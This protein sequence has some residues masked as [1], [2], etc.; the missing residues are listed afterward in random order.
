MIEEPDG[1]TAAWV[2]IIAHVTREARVCLNAAE[3]W[4]ASQEQL[5]AKLALG[6]RL[7]R[8]EAQ[9]LREIA[10]EGQRAIEEQ[11]RQLEALDAYSQALARRF[12]PEDAV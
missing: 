11:R 7:S 3:L 12:T 5:L 6:V 2:S 4:R 8:S 9:T 1:S 10:R